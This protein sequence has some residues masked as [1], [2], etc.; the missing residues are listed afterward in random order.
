MRVPLQCCFKATPSVFSLFF[1]DL[2]VC[3]MQCPVTYIPLTL[4]FFLA[5][6]VFIFIW[7]G[8]Y[9]SAIFLFV[10]GWGENLVN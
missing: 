9:S 10:K 1:I 6:V 8:V 3:H 4:G 7:H 5:G 2:G